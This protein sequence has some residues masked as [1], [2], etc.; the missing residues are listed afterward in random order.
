MF[1]LWKDEL[2][3]EQTDALLDRTAHEI[4]RRKMEA[5]AILFFEMHKPLAFVGS[6][7]ALVFSPFLVPFIGFDRVNDYTRLF[8]KRENI[9]SLLKRLESKDD[10]VGGSEVPC[11]N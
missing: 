5:P 6:Q 4:K 9:E 1:D 7:A 8:S 11:N 3:D 10:S 2:T